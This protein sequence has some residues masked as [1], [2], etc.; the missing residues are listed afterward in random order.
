MPYGPGGI[1]R[2][3]ADIDD[4]INKDHPWHLPSVS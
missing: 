2:N 4:S 1:V 3:D